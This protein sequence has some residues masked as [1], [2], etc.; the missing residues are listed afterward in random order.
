MALK[1]IVCELCGS[2]ELIK[3]D[4]LFR[5]MYCG[6]RYTLEEARKLFV[7]DTVTVRIDNE[8]AYNNSMAL[9]D[10]AM[11]EQRFSDAYMNI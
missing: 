6:T 2:N 8:E 1:A 3:E 9:I 11:K 7:D 10:V 4:G 5:C